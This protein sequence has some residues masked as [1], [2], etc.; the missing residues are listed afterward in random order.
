LEIPYSAIAWSEE[1]VVATGSLC[2][3]QDW[4]CCFA[5]H[6]LYV[7]I[8]LLTAGKMVFCQ[9]VPIEVVPDCAIFPQWTP[10]PAA[11]FN[12]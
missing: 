5:L 2:F 12:A 6:L 9:V 7:S 10:P 1:L 3:R 8:K 11:S 4:H